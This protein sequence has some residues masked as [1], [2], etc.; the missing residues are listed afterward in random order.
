M[1]VSVFLCEFVCI[2]H[3]CNLWRSEEGVRSSG[4]RI[5]GSCDLSD[6]ELGT[7]PPSSMR[8]MCILTCEPSFQYS[9]YRVWDH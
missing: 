2:R 1:C 7:E 8:K 3:V 6:G 9:L 4:T 5:T